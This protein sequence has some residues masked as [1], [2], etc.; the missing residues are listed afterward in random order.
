MAT[1]ESRK[2][3]DGTTRYRALVRVQGHKALSA[4]F[5]TRRKAERWA[6]K[7]E[8]AIHE[9]A[10]LPTAAARRKTLQHVLER[11]E[12]DVAPAL[13]DGDKRLMQ[14]GW[15]VDHLGPV[16]LAALTPARIAEGRDAL[17]AGE[18]PSGKKAS[19]AT[20]NRYLAALS[21]ALSL[22]VREWG[23][24][25]DNPARKVTR[26][27]EPR[28]RVRFLTDTERTDLLD[29]ARA[30]DDP[31]LYPLVVLAICTGGRQGELMALRWRDIHLERGVAIAEQTKNGE[32]RALP[33]TGPALEVVRELAK[34]RRIDDDLIFRS[35]DG[36]TIFPRKAWLAAL[37]AAGLDHP[38]DDPRHL[39][40]HDLRHECASQLAMSG[41]T[42]AEIAEVLGHKTLA[43]VK[44]YS[45]LAEGHTRSVVE[46][47]TGR[48]FA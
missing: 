17:A 29:A 9:G 40:F 34:V 42:L 7:T 3:K 1:I 28:G 47:M 30:S 33:L 23:W 5:G 15:W 32:R 45:H 48:L 11:Y 20:C 2:A 4:T 36:S 12:R 14:L 8:G 25:A 38:H 10:H 27:R 35:D 44:R 22:A 13:A 21:A 19:E 46:R 26:K 37:A 43:M 24:I 16:S 39:T 6:S 41:A 18:G 31:H